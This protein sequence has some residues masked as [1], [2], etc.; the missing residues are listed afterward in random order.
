M[1][2]FSSKRLEDDDIL[3][4]KVI[5]GKKNNKYVYLTKANVENDKSYGDKIKDFYYYINSKSLRLSS[6]S[7][8]NLK[9]AIRDNDISLLSN[10]E[11]KI[12]D[13][14]INYL[15]DGEKHLY[16]DDLFQL[17]PYYEYN[18]KQTQRD[19]IYVCG[20][21]GS[22]K[23]YFISN[24]AK[25]FNDIF[26]ESPIYFISAKNLKD[27]SAYNGVKRIKQIDI[28]NEEMLEDITSEGDSFNYFAD[29]SG[30]SLCIFDDAEAMSKNQ[31]KLVN[32][33]LESI[34]QIGR[35][36]GIYCIVS[37]HVL[38]NN[39]KT[40][41]IIN[42]CNKVVLFT[43]TLSHYSIN[44]FLKN[45]GNYDKNQINKVLSTKSRY[46]IINKN[47]PRYN[48]YERDIVLI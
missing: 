19:V 10:S 38:C 29:D 44:Y 45:Y 37:K 21:S 2:N 35:S 5:D 23:T 36:K 7:E 42:E 12:Y 31:E 30:Y 48:M 26:T 34:L 20:S 4:A 32:N 33:I 8:T 25:Q 43:N 3:I 24:Y 11:K 13:A 39:Q 16:T 15:N 14:F 6:T 28:K 46:C 18:S 47:I 1:Y 27:E 17:I 41:V 22:G 40:K 9:I